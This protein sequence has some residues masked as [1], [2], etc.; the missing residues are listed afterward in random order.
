ML[1]S[2]KRIEQ[3]AGRTVFGNDANGYAEGRPDYPARV[4]DI[5]RTTCRATPSTRVFEIG[6]GTGQATKRLLDLGCAV[7]A[8][9]PDSR[10]ADVLLAKCKSKTPGRLS[11]HIAAFED[12]DF[13]DEKFDLGIAATSFHW[14]EQESA[15]AKAKRLLKPGGQWA[16]WWT[17]FGDSS[18]EDE[19]QRRTRSLFANLWRSPSHG[20]ES[21]VPFA[22]DAETRKA[23]LR[24]AGFASVSHELIHWTTTQTTSQVLALT[25]TFAPVAQ[26]PQTE[27]EI[28]MKRLERIA[29]L[30]FGG[31]VA[32]N[33]VTVVYTAS[34]R[35]DVS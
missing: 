3:S 18:R 23:Q 4:Y 33:F 34:C 26:L 27:R 16:M 20:S 29:D 13:S 19:F 7:T 22:L 31:V 32:R 15:L 10:L 5:L 25:S 28:L 35:S 2:S 12:V 24:G 11:L 30:E 8:I 9:E 6:P 1:A 14:L 17:I 21:Q